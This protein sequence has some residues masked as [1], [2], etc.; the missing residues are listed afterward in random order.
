MEERKLVRNVKTETIHN[1]IMENRKKLS[2]S[3]VYDVESFNEEEIVLHTEQGIMIVRGE[4][5]HISKLSTEVGEVVIDGSICAIEYVEGK[6]KGSG[7]F[8]SKMFK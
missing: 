2:V 8:L 3:G 4:G 6:A 1:I 5:L 7:G